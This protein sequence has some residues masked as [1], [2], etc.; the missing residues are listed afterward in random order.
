MRADLTHAGVAD[1]AEAGRLD[2]HAMRKSLATYL[3]AQG[4][5]Q[6]LTQ[7]HLRHSDPRL[8]AG[9]YTDET[10][11]PVAA[12]I[13][14]LPPLPTEP[15]R[16]AEALRMTGTCDSGAAHAQR[17]AHSGVLTGSPECANVG[18]AATPGDDAQAQEKTATCAAVHGDSRKRVMGLEPTTFTL[19][20]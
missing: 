2:L 6:R 1:V 3:A 18:S 10:L 5:S 17:A 20:T 4:V 11:L 14:E 12:P 9:V 7:A 13:A 15:V 16:P 8:T 19:A